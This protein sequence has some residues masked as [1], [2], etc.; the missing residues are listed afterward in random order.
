MC[1]NEWK[2]N[3]FQNI[4]QAQRDLE[5]KMADIQKQMIEHGNICQLQVE[6]K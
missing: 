6:E 2:K 4:F 3:V 1:L 5:N